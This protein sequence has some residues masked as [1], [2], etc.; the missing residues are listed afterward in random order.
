MAKIAIKAMKIFGEQAIERNSLLV[1]E[2]DHFLG[3]Y[4]KQ[5][6]ER[7]KIPVQDYGDLLILPG[8]VD[9]HIHGAVGSDT[10]D[11]TPEALKKIGDFLLEAGTTAWMPTTVT[12]EIDAICRAVANVKDCQDMKDTARIIGCFVEG[13]YIT[14]E[15][16]GAQPEH[17]I[18]PLDQAEVE[19]IAAAGIVSVLAVAPEKENAESFIKW[20]TKKGIKISLAHS[21]ATYEESC[22]GIKAGADA[23][24]HTFC[25]M[26][27]LHH[28]SPNLV[29]AALV[30][31]DVY[32][33]LIADG[34]HVQAPA[35]KILL[36]CKPDEKVILVSDAIQATG[37]PDGEYVLGV[38]P[39]IVKNGISRVSNGSLAGSTTTLLQEVRRLILELGTEP[40]SAVH[41]A[42]LNPSRRL[43]VD[44]KI[45]SIAKGKKADFIVV[46]RKYQL[47]ETWLNG[48]RMVKK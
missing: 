11:A 10:M 8:L 32:A 1:I 9:S 7:M 41:M 12:T 27:S 18:R 42:S 3:F 35:M 22:Q 19:K 47:K 17:L 48:V 40:L 23:V 31:D 21:S 26:K 30:E 14:K 43:G 34:I 38:E 6:V 4:H 46:D 44:K 15:C 39:I 37:L 25:G 16:R 36:R 45:G 24:V 33:E 13:P 5:D 20:A 29:G 2:D 28:R